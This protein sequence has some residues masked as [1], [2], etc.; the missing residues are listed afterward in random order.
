VDRPFSPKIHKRIPVDP[1]AL[2]AAGLG[3]I[4]ADDERLQRFLALTGIDPA[5][6]RAA[7]AEP[8]FALAVL[9]FIGEDDA[10]TLAFAA[11]NGL[12]GEDVAAARQK[13]AGPADWAGD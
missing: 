10:T 1:V 12:S 13:L 7:A 2:A 5:A 3:F 8:G 4:A 6:I 9:D 11:E